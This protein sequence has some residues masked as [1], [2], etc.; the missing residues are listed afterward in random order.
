MRR[1]AATDAAT[2]ATQ[3]HDAAERAG[4]T[5][6]AA[7]ALLMRGRAQEAVALPDAALNDLTRAAAG[8]RAAGDPRLEMLALHELGGDVPVSLGLPITYNETNLERGLQIAESLGDRA[9]QA[10][11]LSRLAVVAANRLDYDRALDHGLRGLAAGRASGAEQAL[12][13]GLDGLKTAY[14]GIGDV[15]ALSEVLAELGPLVRR[16][17]DPFRLQWVEFESAFVCVVAADWDGAAQA[18]QAGIEANRRAGYPHFTSWYVTHLG[19][20][21]RLRGHDDEAVTQGRRA[22][23]LIERYP[24]PWALALGCAML[25]STLL[26]AGDRAEAIRL[27]ER[28]LAAAEEAGVESGVL[29]CAAPLAAATGSRG[30]LDQAAGVLAAASIPDGGA[31]VLGDEAYLSLARAWLARG[32]PERARPVL[33]PLLAVARRV[34]GSPRSRP[35]SPWTDARS[36]SWG[37]E[38]QPPASCARRPSWPASTAC[39]MCCAR[40]S[41]PSAACG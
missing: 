30:V 40:R 29:H 4:D 31:W 38:R 1:Y 6:V 10:D 17:G 12:A 14:V 16:L 18:I 39:R 13:D 34:P 11:L 19:W 7:R 5:E 21:A 32:E 41:S 27:F 8:A 15:P 37:T 24:H 9:S 26:L 25:G 35:R 20:L 3:A 36:S 33:A 22:L 23:A 28:G 2:L